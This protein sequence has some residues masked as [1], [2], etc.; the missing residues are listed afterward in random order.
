LA[1]RDASNKSENEKQ[2]V[3]FSSVLAAIFLTAMKLVVGLLTGS[4]GILSEAAH[5]G[6]DLIAAVVT[7]FA[8]RVSDRP[9]DEVHQFGHGKVENLSALIE[10]LLLFMTCVWIV[11]EA[12]SRLF[13]KSVEV[14]VNIWAFAVMGISIIVDITRSRALMKAAKA[15]NSQALEADAL[16]FSTDV[17]SSSVVIIGLIVVRAGDIVQLPWLAKADAIAALVVACIVIY[18]SGRLGKRAVSVLLDAAPLGL[19]EQIE[20]RVAAI[21]GISEVRQIRVRQAGPQTFVDLTIA[22]PQDVSLQESHHIAGRTED[23][24]AA[25]A[26]SADVI[27]HVETLQ[28]G[29][30]NL[31]EQVRSIAAGHGIRVHGL[32]AHEV[33]GSVNLDLHVEVDQSLTLQQAHDLVTTFEQDLIQVFGDKLEVVSH[34]EPD[35]SI[36]WTRP[37]PQAED[38]LQIR[39]EVRETLAR[40]CGPDAV[41]DINLVIDPAG[42]RDLTLH[43]HLSGETSIIQAH[44]ISEQ[45]EATIRKR[46][47]DLDRIVVHVEPIDE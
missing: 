17:W 12:I 31:P 14:D 18:V 23:A 36:V 5:S 34:I 8:V 30:E 2:S 33:A 29:E 11:Y 35:I 24:V 38:N 6:L 46:F 44:H 26:S 19:R 25:I 28:P 42:R 41:H 39:S 22:L 1:I 3:A 43:C 32:H 4:L 13:F 7:F 45:A 15:H 9:A 47:P 10:T 20:G 21:P 16:H 40:L 37:V 27:V